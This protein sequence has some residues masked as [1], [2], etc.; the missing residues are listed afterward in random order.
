MTS[1]SD[2]RHPD[3]QISDGEHRQMEVKE[4]RRR[5]YI[6]RRTAGRRGQGAGVEDGRTLANETQ[7]EGARGQANSTEG[8]TVRGDDADHEHLEDGGSYVNLAIDFSYD[9]RK[10]KTLGQ[11]G[12]WDLHFLGY[13]G[14]GVK[15]LASGE[16]R[17]CQFT[18][19]SS[20]KE[21]ADM[22]SMKLSGSKC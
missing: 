1:D 13:F 6:L 19:V 14:F 16:I 21:L 12:G 7:E 11:R 4:R 3:D 8:T 5:D 9:G 22:G 20:T 15:G 18:S 10:N 2:P 17:E